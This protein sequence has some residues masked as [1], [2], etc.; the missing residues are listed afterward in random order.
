MKHLYRS[1]YA[2]IAFAAAGAGKGA[3]A[4]QPVPAPGVAATVPLPVDPAAASGDQSSAA[5]PVAAVKTEKSVKTS[6]IRA[7]IPVPAKRPPGLRGGKPL[8][9]FEGLAVSQSFGVFDKTFKQVNSTVSSANKRAKSVPDLNTNGTPKTIIA[10]VNGVDT[11]VPAMKKE[12]V[13]FASSVDPKT[14]P[15]QASVRVW[16][17]A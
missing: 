1:S 6:P 7:D 8:Y 14:D 5:A 17:T 4:P 3:A 11:P 12:K 9:D 13:F 2:V 15:D 10:K 16:R